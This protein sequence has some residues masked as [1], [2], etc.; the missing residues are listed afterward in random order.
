MLKILLFSRG[1]KAPLLRW[2]WALKISVYMFSFPNSTSYFKYFVYFK[3]LYFPTLIPYK[4][5]YIDRAR[6][7]SSKAPFYRY[8]VESTLTSWSQAGGRLLSPRLLGSD[9]DPGARGERPTPESF[10]SPS[11]SFGLAGPLSWL[12]FSPIGSENTESAPLSP[13]VEGKKNFLSSTQSSYF[14]LESS[15]QTS[16]NEIFVE[17]IKRKRIVQVVDS[18]VFF[19]CPHWAN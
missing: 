1:W 6:N 7:G 5:P 17:I 9:A 2:W 4:Q 14:P 12:R 10:V 3:L 13:A 19:C 11:R 15:K 8:I 18:E 16:S